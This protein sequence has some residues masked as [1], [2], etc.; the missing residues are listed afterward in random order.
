MDRR[1]VRAVGRHA[2]DLRISSS[3]LWDSNP[4]PANGRIASERFTPEICSALFLLLDAAEC[5]QDGRT[6]VWQF[7]IELSVLLEMGLTKNDCRWLIAKGLC[8][9]A[10]ES[11]THQTIHRTFRPY[12]NLALPSG[13]CFV[14]SERGAVYAKA[15]QR[16]GAPSNIIRLDPGFSAHDKSS[17]N[18]GSS[19]PT[20]PVW[21]ADRQQLR[22]GSTVVKEF[23]VPA[24]NQQAVL[25]AF[26]EENWAPRIDDPL[27]P[28][29]NQDPKRR[30]H[31]TINCLNRNQKHALIRFLGDGKGEGVR[32]EF[33]AEDFGRDPSSDAVGF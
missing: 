23:K 7:S 33:A 30:L 32:W 28:A 21:D 26:Q 4:E 15:L 27:P 9:H 2:D 6:D 20:V 25:G 19:E 12:A 17:S 16:A 11:T 5:A 18:N 8:K 13:T 29:P 1:R 3:G 10:C 31:S 22:V 14:I 24:A